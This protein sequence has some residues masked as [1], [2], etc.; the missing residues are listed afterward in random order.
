MP[1]V[2]LVMRDVLL[3]NGFSFERPDVKIARDAFK[4]FAV[5]RIPGHRPFCAGYECFHAEHPRDVL[6]LSFERRFDDG[7]V[8]T[9]CVFSHV[10]PRELWDVNDSTWHWPEHGGLDEW[11]SGRTTLQIRR[12]RRSSGVAVGRV[13]R[14]RERRPASSRLTFIIK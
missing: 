9:G 10:V 1:E 3:R 11:L 13:L 8:T 6:W 2:D 5:L 4:R 7:F 12:S 14:L